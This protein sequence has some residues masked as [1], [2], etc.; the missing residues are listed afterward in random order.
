MKTLLIEWKHFEKKGKT[1][2]RCNKT[3]DSLKQAIEELRNLLLLK[4]FTIQLIETRFPEDQMDESNGLFFNGI[5]LENLLNKV[6]VIKNTCNSCGD[7]TGNP[8][9]C[10]A[11]QTDNTV[12][13]D[14]PKDMIKQAILKSLE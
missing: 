10:R 12:Y 14:I 13:D 9:E 5:P 3:G 2:F 8:C 6:S 1:C 11:I 4:G 7:L